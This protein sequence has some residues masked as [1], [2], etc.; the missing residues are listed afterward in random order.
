MLDVETAGRDDAP[1]VTELPQAIFVNP[2]PAFK[3]D[4]AALLADSKP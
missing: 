2:T 3:A 1:L 4:L